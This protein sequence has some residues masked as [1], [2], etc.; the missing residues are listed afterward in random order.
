MGIKTKIEK[1]INDINNLYDKTINVLTKSFLQKHENLLKE[2]NEIKETLQIEVTKIKETLENFL[3]QT[4]N[5]I[6]INE[7]IKEG[8]KKIKNEKKYN[9]KF[10]IY[11]KNK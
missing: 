11:F 5:Q 4:N 3:S 7:R 9:S 1:E 6:K 10:N 8:I 2:E